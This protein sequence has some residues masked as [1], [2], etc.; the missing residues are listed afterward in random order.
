MSLIKCS[1]CGK[2]I[3]NRAD[4]CPSCGNPIHRAP[5]ENEE[6]IQKVEIEQTNKKWKKTG[7]L[8]VVVAFI[9]IML[10]G[11]SIWLGFFVLFIAVIIGQY[12]RFGAWWDNG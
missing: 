9:G 2:E 12:A 6:G 1:E 11:K 4:A 8:S 3:S 5:I 7:C 10:M